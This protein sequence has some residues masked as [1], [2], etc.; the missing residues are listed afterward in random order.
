MHKIFSIINNGKLKENRDFQKAEELVDTAEPHFMN[1][2]DL[3][4][5]PGWRE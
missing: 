1:V 2:M 3:S 5:K 4:G